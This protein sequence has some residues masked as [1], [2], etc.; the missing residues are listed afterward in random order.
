[1]SLY[2]PQ[3]GMTMRV[4]WED[5][6]TG[7]PILQQTSVLRILARNITVE[8]NDYT[9]ADTFSCEIDYKSFPFDPRTVRSIGVT[10]HMEDRERVFAGN[11]LDLMETT[12]DNTSFIGFADE[13]SIIFDDDNRIVRMEGRD[14]TSLFLDTKRTNTTPLAFSLPIDVIIFNLMRELKATE[15]ISIELRLGTQEILPVLSQLAPDFNPVTANKNPKRNENYW[16]LIQTIAEKAGLIVFIELDKLVLSKPQ[17]VYSRLNTVQCIYGYNLKTLQFKRKIGRQKGFNVKV[18]SL[19]VEAKKTLE[20]LL[21]EDAKDTTDPDTAEFISRFGNTRIKV[22]QLDK[23]GKKIDP[24]KDAD[25]LTFRVADIASKK[26]L[27]TLGM[28]IYEELSR[29]E[30]E[31]SLMTYEMQLPVATAKNKHGQATEADIISFNKVRNG[32]AIEIIIEADDLDHIQTIS[33]LALRRKFLIRRGYPPEIAA[34]FAESMNRVHNIFYTK[35]VKFT[36]SQDDGFQMD[37]DF[38]NQIELDNK[39]L[40]F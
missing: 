21:P 40:G 22:I 33:N 23:D 28:K 38:I 25:F 6:E 31:G 24:P 35:A 30:I 20:A 18:V 27:I 5:F 8:I 7:L 39:D 3:G 16:D 15:D 13:E 17:V 2:Y 34:A 14:F 36:L 11:I 32:T 26:H 4:T 37:I 12:R 1:M 29:Q 10:I 9:E 19:N